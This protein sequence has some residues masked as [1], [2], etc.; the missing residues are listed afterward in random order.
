MVDK[1]GLGG[2]VLVA[3]VQRQGVG[4]LVE[5]DHMLATGLSINHQRSDA[6]SRSSRTK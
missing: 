1:P 2:V 3:V 5:V 4:L 6:F